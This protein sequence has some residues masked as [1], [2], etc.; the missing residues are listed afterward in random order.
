ME[1]KKNKD[2]EKFLRDVKFS[3]RKFR[4]KFPAKICSTYFGKEKILGDTPRKNF[5]EKISGKN[6]QQLFLP[7]PAA[8]KICNI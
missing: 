1:L 4:K 7:L 5:H 3:Q 8:T 2:F 6:F